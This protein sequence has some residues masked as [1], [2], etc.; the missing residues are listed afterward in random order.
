MA[1]ATGLYLLY[2]ALVVAWTMLMSSLV[3]S[4]VGAGGLALVPLFAIPTVTLLS[5]RAGDYL[6]FGLIVAAGDVVRLRAPVDALW[7]A[8]AITAVLAAAC[9]LATHGRVRSISF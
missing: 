7:V 5:G 6:P 8:V 2:G 1:A 4:G 3:K 9:G